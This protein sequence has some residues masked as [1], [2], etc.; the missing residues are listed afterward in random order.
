MAQKDKQFGGQQSHQ[1]SYSS[2]ESMA[3]QA[4]GTATGVMESAR[5]AASTA[6][7]KAGDAASYVGDKA[8]SATSAVGSGMKSLAGTIREHT[9]REGM[10]GSATSAVADTLESSGRYL[11]E[12][13]LS[14]IGDDLTSMIRRNPV[15]ALL[16]GIGL[17]FL[18]A[19]A[20]RS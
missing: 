6:A 5:E 8:E 11:E 10:L 14:G 9:P 3:E 16:V 2:H 13:G 1:Q 18:I 4:K 19:R 20:T 7:R 12:S 15:P 17:G